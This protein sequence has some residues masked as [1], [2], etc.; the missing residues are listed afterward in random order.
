MGRFEWEISTRVYRKALLTFP[1]DY[2]C[3]T[4]TQG[5]FKG[6]MGIPYLSFGLGMASILQKGF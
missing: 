4:Y 2:G 5:I 6:G 3:W 1:R